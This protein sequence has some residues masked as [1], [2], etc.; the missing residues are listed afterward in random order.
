[1]WWSRTESDSAGI[2]AAFDWTIQN[3]Y[4]IR[5]VANPST[6]LRVREERCLAAEPPVRFES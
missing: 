6:R 2:L 5:A 4:K 3:D 1:M